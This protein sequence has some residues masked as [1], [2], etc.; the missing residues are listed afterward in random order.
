MFLKKSE[1]KYKLRPAL[2]RENIQ[3]QP[4]YSPGRGWYHIYTFCPGKKDVEQLK[5]LPLEEQESLVLLRL[6]IGQF[7]EKEID[8]DTLL[9][10][11]MIL[12]RFQNAKKEY[13]TSY[14]L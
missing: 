5:W 13:H 4:Y 11:E 7:R 6:D 9:F 2:N 14:L 12:K 8:R 1:Y 3:P 10:T